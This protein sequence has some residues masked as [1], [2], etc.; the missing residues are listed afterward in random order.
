MHKVLKVQNYSELFYTIIFLVSLS[1]A[2]LSIKGSEEA[3]FG[4]LG[5][6]TVIFMFVSGLVCFKASFK[7]MMANNVS[8]KKFYYGN[9]AALVT[10]AAFMA[11][12]D[13]VLNGILSRVI[14]YESLV[15]QLYGTSTHLAEFL[16]SFG[17][18]AFSV[19]L[20][21]LITT[22][23]YRANRIMKIVVSVIPF[24][25]GVLFGYID[26]QT[27]RVASRA[28]SGFIGRAM[29]FTANN[30]YFGAFSFVAGTA[31]LLWASF[32][33]IRRAPVKD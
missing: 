11:M 4:G 27:G 14:P 9:M 30:A 22:I 2:V 20:G 33:L 8:R 15:V 21:L 10:I 12:V 26:G 16:W 32:I 3:T 23:Y 28:L 19:C 7:F 5:T 24:V 17:L 25:I 13:T 1:T 31:V 18:Y 29:G 6:A